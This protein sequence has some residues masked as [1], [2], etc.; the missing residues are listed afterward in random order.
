MVANFTD[1]QRD[2]AEEHF[3]TRTWPEEFL[4]GMAVIRDKVPLSTEQWWSTMRKILQQINLRYR[5]DA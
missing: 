2:W 1:E 3:G 5:A 4:R